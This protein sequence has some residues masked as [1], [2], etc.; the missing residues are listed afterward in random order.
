MKKII[1]WILIL[2]GLVATV[3]FSIDVTNNNL[4]NEFY[5]FHFRNGVKE[6]NSESLNPRIRKDTIIQSLS[7]DEIGAMHS[8]EQKKY[9]EDLDNQQH[10]NVENNEIYIEKPI[11]FYIC[12]EEAQYSHKRNFDDFSFSF[13]N[14]NNGIKYNC[15][16]L[17]E[18]K[19][20]SRS[21]LRYQFLNDG[22]ARGKILAEIDIKTPGWYIIECSGTLRFNGQ[23]VLITNSRMPVFEGGNVV[24]MKIKGNL[25]VSI[26]CLAFSGLFLL[27]VTILFIKKRKRE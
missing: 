14:I 20:Y 2:V 1:Y 18:Q 27:S 5:Y 21:S 17:S 12:Y 19:T 13:I 26:I 25:A 9:Y 4:G 6:H 3:Y 8:A 23:T 10:F 7:F 22:F 16:V 15:S 11:R 24:A